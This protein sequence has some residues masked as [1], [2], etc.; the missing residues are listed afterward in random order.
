MKTK[1]YNRHETFLAALSDSSITVPNPLSREELYLAKIAGESVTIPASPDNRYETYLAKL[2]GEDVTV[3]T[4][5]SR[6]ECYLYKA[7]GY[8]CDVPVPANREEIFWC[9]YIGK[10]VM[11]DPNTGEIV[12][13][14]GADNLKVTSFVVVVPIKQNGSGDPS[15]DNVRDIVVHN[16]LTIYQSGPDT[17]DP[18]SIPISWGDSAGDV[19]KGVYDAINGTLT[20]THRVINLSGSSWAKSGNIFYRNISWMKTGSSDEGNTDAICSTYKRAKGSTV[21]SVNNTFCSGSTYVSKSTIGIHDSR[22]TTVADFGANVT[23]QMLLPL[24]ENG[25]YN[26]GGND[27]TTHAGENHFWTDVGTIIMHYTPDL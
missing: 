2:A 17:S 18:T 8:D 25:I 14:D 1:P 21:A 6:L 20:L 26:L 9:R 24:K 13:M 7:C 19:A 27:I 5:A 16:G 3:P 10:D 12:I 22:Y 11:S 4:P 15:P 23:G